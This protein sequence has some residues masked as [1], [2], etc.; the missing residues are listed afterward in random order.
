MTALLKIVPLWTW[1]VLAALIAVGVQSWRLHSVQGERD[2]IAQNLSTA[3]THIDALKLTAGLQQ[4]L[5]VEASASS[6]KYQGVIADAAQQ[7]SA[8]ASD[9]AATRK[10]LQVHGQCVRSGP[11][12]GANVS[13]SDATTFRL[14]A[15]AQRNYLDLRSGIIQQRAQIIG[16]QERVLSLEKSCK[17]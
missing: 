11:T 13:G 10:R 5:A 6:T 3:N 14:D 1:I 7:N 12:S 17:I 8:L 2:E 9:L 15:E 4:Q 16:L